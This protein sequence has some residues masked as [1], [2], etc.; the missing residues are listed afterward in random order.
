MTK[1][2]IWQPRY[3]LHIKKTYG[4]T[5]VTLST[6]K[7]F[8]KKDNVW[9]H[10]F[11]H[12]FGIVSRITQHPLRKIHAA[13]P[14]LSGLLVP[15]WSMI[16]LRQMAA[17]GEEYHMRS[18]NKAKLTALPRNWTCDP[19]L[20]NSR[21]QLTH[22]QHGWGSFIISAKKAHCFCRNDTLVDKKSLSLFTTFQNEENPECNHLGQPVSYPLCWICHKLP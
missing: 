12:A 13:P 1:K 19:D 9:K 15:L 16:C 14:T 18:E 2:N 22:H 7:I 17:L 21:K 20:I 6:I 5:Y 10:K 4:R 8:K 11:A 3:L